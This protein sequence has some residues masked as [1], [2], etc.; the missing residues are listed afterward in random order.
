MRDRQLLQ[1]RAGGAPATRTPTPNWR[2]EPPSTVTPR[3]PALLST[4]TSQLS[5]S[6]QGS[7]GVPSPSM[8]WPL[9]CR[10][11]L[12]A[13]ITMPLFGQ[14]T[15]SLSSVVSVVMGSPQP[16]WLAYAGLLPR[17]VKLATT[18]ARTIALESTVLGDGRRGTLRA[19]RD[20]SR[21]RLGMGASPCD[22]TAN[23]GGGGGSFHPV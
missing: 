13:P 1:A 8:V 21:S 4:P 5:P 15:R 7:T 18:K 3:W 12:S 23:P 11:R 14:L 9:S 6:G 22:R 20:G 17:T 19:S 10:V 16:T 2:T